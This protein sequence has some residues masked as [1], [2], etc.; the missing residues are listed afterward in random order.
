MTPRY[1]IEF[2][3][4]PF[5]VS[6]NLY[7]YRHILIQMVI[8][9]LKGRFAGS[10]GGMLW[11]FVHPILM[12]VIFLFVFVYI[13]KVRVGATGS[14]ALS[15]IYLMSGLFPWIIMA[16]GLS[17]GTSS[18]FENANLIQKTFF[19]TEILPAKAVV[20]PFLS[21]GIAI[22]LLSLYAVLFMHKSGVI[23]LML[24]LVLLLQALFTLGISFLTSTV[25][26]F[27][28]DIM[29]LVQVAI[30]FWIYLT[31][32]LYPVD[33]LPEWARVAMF[34]NPLYPLISLYQSLLLNG[35]IENWYM[36]LLALCWSLG[37]FVAGSFFFTKLKY[38][39]A[40]WL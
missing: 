5:A 18:L 33:M 12:L 1:A 39:F 8:R 11:H 22:I 26:V 13:F 38:E 29:Q 15:S 40:D 19:P 32:I 3:K 27:F 20:T 24:P 28:R 34:I 23:M 35:G 37:F 2:F 6:K 10:M 31:P 17:R 14:S 9:E 25:S 4:S 21:Y 7:Q 16:E 30:S 36:P